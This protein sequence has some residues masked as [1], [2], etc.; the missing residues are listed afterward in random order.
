MDT[1]MGYRIF[2]YPLESNHSIR[3]MFFASFSLGI[4]YE[5][6]AYLSNSSTTQ[7]DSTRVSA[8]YKRLGVDLSDASLMAQSITHKSF[9]HGSVP[10]NER[11]GHLG[12]KGIF[13]AWITMGEEET[14]LSY[15]R[16]GSED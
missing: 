11:L 16:A 9:S 7:D 6:R 15:Y 2:S 12:K 5:A 8:V 13:K 10:T 3:G 4:N 1:F 14:R